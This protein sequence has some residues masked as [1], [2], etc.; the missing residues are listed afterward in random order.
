M[1][2]GGEQISDLIAERDAWQDTAAQYL[3]NADY[4]RGLVD[5]IGKVPGPPAYVQDDGGIVDRPLRAKVPELVIA[6]IAER[7]ALREQLAAVEKVVA[8]ALDDEVWH[9]STYMDLLNT[10]RRLRRA[11][12][13][14]P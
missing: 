9:R 7:D 13:E 1:T 3:R 10:L 4:Y 12:E 8:E 2:L 14:K 5:Q 11:I 6:L